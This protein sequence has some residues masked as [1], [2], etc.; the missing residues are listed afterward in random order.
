MIRHFA[1]AEELDRVSG[2][3]ESLRHL[4]QLLFKL[5]GEVCGRREPANGIVSPLVN[6]AATFPGAFVASYQKLKR[7]AHI[8]QFR[9]FDYTD[10]AR[11]SSRA[12][13]MHFV[14]PPRSFG[15]AAPLAL[16]DNFQ[17]AEVEEQTAR[18]SRLTVAE[19]KEIC[20]ILHVERSGDKVGTCS[21]HGASFA[22]R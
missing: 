2:A 21:S 1:V 17:E 9:G 10:K 20:T 11:T 19:I 15:W 6:V 22:Q 16:C 3:A 5:P 4:H 14:R 12:C 7:K 18:V 13:P 8:R